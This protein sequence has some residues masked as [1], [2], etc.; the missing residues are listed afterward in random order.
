MAINSNDLKS[1]MDR[2]SRMI[3]DERR[4]KA[5]EPAPEDPNRRLVQR[6]NALWIVSGGSGGIGLGLSFARWTDAY[7]PGVGVIHWFV[8]GMGL[9]FLGAVAVMLTVHNRRT[10]AGQ[11]QIVE[12]VQI[13]A[14]ILQDDIRDARPADAEDLA[15]LAAQHEA[16]HTLVRQLQ[17]QIANLL[18]MLRDAYVAGFRDARNAGANSAGRADD[19][20]VVDLDDARMLKRIDERLKQLRP[21]EDDL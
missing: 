6:R 5:P 3:A 10:I 12:L 19:S 21:E 8:V 4:A 1:I 2:V 15:R 11:R 16:T 17:G 7:I 20:D 13:A 14:A 18:P 9:A